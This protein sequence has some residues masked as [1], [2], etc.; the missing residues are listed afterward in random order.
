MSDPDSRRHAAERTPER[1]KGALSERRD[2]DDSDEILQGEIVDIITELNTD[3]EG[4]V[5]RGELASILSRTIHVS[6]RH[7]GPLPTADYIREIGELIDDGSERIMAMAEREQAHRHE[8]TNRQMSLFEK[9]QD[10]D[11]KVTTRGQVLGFIIC[12]IVLLTGIGFAVA[13]FPKLAGAVIL[14]DL[15]ALATVFVVGRHSSSSDSESD[16]GDDDDGESD[17]TP[18][19]EEST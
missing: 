16:D 11:Y 10:D 19:I 6:R 4:T 1:P 18:A 12:I 17:G 8:M 3:G 5:Q 14:V 9:V 13:G 2:D 15:V 7:S